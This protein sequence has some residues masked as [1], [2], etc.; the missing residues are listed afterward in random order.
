MG[1][2]STIPNVK[3]EKKPVV[4]TK[5]KIVCF[6]IFRRKKSKEAQKGQERS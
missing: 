6:N 5:S 1:K 2:K 4:T 3:A